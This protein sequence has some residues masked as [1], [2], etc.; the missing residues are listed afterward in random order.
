MEL[1]GSECRQKRGGVK[2]LLLN[3]GVLRLSVVKKNRNQQRRMEQMPVRWVEPRSVVPWKPKEVSSKE[4]GETNTAK[5][6]KVGS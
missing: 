4:E 5:S 2:G 1:L 6:S 3:P